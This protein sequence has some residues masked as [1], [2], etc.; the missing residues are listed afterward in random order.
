MPNVQQAFSASP[1]HQA[2][3]TSHL[4]ASPEERHLRAVFAG[5]SPGY[6]DPDPSGSFPLRDIC[7]DAARH[8]SDAGHLT[9]RDIRFLSERFGLD[10]TDP[11]AFYDGLLSL[12]EDDP[13]LLPVIEVEVAQNR[14]GMKRGRVASRAAHSKIPRVISKLPLAKLRLKDNVGPI[15]RLAEFAR[16]TKMTADL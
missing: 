15:G 4:G 13:W 6:R 14:S 2:A 8:F 1:K 10:G 7:P 9:L 16:E 11:E 12:A 3:A 5:W